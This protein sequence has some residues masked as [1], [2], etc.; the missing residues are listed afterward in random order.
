VAVASRQHEGAAP[1]RRLLRAR[2]CQG[3]CEGAR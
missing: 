1:L 2:V 3:L